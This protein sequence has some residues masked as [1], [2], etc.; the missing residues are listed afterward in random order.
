MIQYAYE[1]MLEEIVI[2]MELFVEVYDMFIYA[3]E[4]G[5]DTP[6]WEEL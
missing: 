2:R 1:G 4:E 6:S 3:K 5:L